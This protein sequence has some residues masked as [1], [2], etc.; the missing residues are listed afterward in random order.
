LAGP[1]RFEPFDDIL[2]LLL[3]RAELPIAFV[4]FVRVDFSLEADSA[5][6]NFGDMK[7]LGY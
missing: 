6:A 5:S 2:P 4:R 3:R 1:P 7:T